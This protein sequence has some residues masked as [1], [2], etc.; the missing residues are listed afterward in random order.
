[1]LSCLMSD[2]RTRTAGTAWALV[3]NPDT[4]SFK[5][6]DPHGATG[7]PDVKSLVSMKCASRRDFLMSARAMARQADCKPMLGQDDGRAVRVFL[8]HPWPSDDDI[9]NWGQAKGK[10][11]P[12]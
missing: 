4:C 10:P 12:I 5:I 2:G 11:A 1:M 3:W 7:L 8:S 9:G 6:E